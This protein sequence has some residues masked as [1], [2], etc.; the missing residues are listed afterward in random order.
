MLPK[1]ERVKRSEF[2]YIL[3]NSKKFSS[4]HLLLYVAKISKGG[5]DKSKF[6]FS[7][8]KKISKK[9]VVRNRLR[10]R[11]YSIISKMRKEIKN[12]FY[13]FFIYKG[14]PQ[15]ISFKILEEEI[16]GLLFNSGVLI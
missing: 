16:R 6:S 10:R 1:K 2:D 9:A 8:S 3:K 11:G 14:D 13:Y 7:A 12:G 5:L 15:N 4:N